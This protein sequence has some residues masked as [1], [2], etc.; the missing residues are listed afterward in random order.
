MAAFPLILVLHVLG[1][2]FWFG[3]TATVA[4][5]NG[6]RAEQLFLPQMGAAILAIAT[7]AT[8]AAW[9]PLQGLPHLRFALLLGAG[10]ALAA[11]LVQLSLV[12]GARVALQKADAAVAVLKRRMAMGERIAAG[13]LALTL[14]SM[15][16]MRYV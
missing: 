2:A 6:E 7:G 14:I 4:R 15:T 10:C 13:L 11:L 3:S 5:L 8:L 1:A 9:L 12:G 16:A